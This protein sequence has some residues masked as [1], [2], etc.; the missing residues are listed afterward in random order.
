MALFGLGTPEIILLLVVA[1]IFFFGAPKVKDWL[2]TFN[3]TKK[4]AKKMVKE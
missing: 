1:A 2:S 3:K 4:E